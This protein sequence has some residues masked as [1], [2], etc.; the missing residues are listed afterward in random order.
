[1]VNH[2]VIQKIMELILNLKALAYLCRPFSFIELS[3][4]D[5]K[6]RVNCSC[7]MFHNETMTITKSST[8]EIE[9]YIETT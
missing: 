4:K 6:C 1:M 7:N 9:C 5:K 3:K 8:E 2:F